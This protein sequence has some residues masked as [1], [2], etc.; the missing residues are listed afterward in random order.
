MNT[1]GAPSFG[2]GIDT[3]PEYSRFN[4]LNLL[5]G[6]W[7]EGDGEVVVDAGTAD[8]EDFVVGETIE[9][10][11]LQPKQDFEV[12]GIAKYG[13]V[14]SIGTATFAIFDVATAQKL[15]DREGSTTRSPSPRRR[16]RRPDAARRRTSSRSSPPTP[17]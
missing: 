1:N 2:F 9:I 6:R 15:Y 13:N 12:V 5:E 3:A 11:T 17:R 16:E 4:P 8:R 14:E 7:P 10:S